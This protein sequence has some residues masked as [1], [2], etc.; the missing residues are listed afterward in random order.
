MPPR[1]TKPKYRRTPANLRRQ[2]LVDATLACLRKFGHEGVSVRRISA[3]AGVSPGLINHHF[4]SITT[5]AAAAYETLAMSVLHSIRRHAQLPGAS[6]RERLRRF[7]EASFTPDILDPELFN[8]W[9]VFWSRV[10]HDPEMRAVYDRTS[11]AYRA[12]IESM[13]AQL[14][15]AADVPSFNV[16]LAGIALVALLDGLWISSSLN[17]KTFKPSDA[18]ALC[19][20]WTDGLCTGAFN[21]VRT[22]R[23]PRVP[24]LQ[25]AAARRGS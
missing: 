23:A 5:L 6:P 18:V 21:N 15:R 12:T 20:D 11:E 22:G 13:L 1:H 3:Q 4:P 24:R 9:L 10:S 2:A 17:P 16:R 8:V 19:E 14:Q 25:A 7:F